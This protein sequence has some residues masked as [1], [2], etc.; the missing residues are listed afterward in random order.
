MAVILAAG[1]GSRFREGGDGTH[2]LLAEWRGQPLVWWAVSSA[3]ETGL[4]ATWV[5]TGSTRLEGVLPEGVEI[6]PNPRWSEGQATS[7]QV[8]IRRAGQAGVDAVVV[9]LGDQPLVTAGAWSAVA[10]STSPIAVATYS[11]RRRNPVRLGSEVWDLLPS[12]GDSGAR[13]VFDQRPELVNEV[14][15]DGDPVDIDTREDLARW[16]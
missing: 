8:A 13:V 9:G 14:P 10:A 6:L 11:G 7:L 3:L 4:D 2:K 12:E 16:S 1:G 5:V 15:C